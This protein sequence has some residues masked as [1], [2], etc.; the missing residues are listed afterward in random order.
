MISGE[1]VVLASVNGPIEVKLQNLVI[2][3]AYVEVNFRSK[4]G[5][6][7]VYDRLREQIIKETCEGAI[8]TA[9]Y[10]KTNISIQLQEMEDKSGVCYLCI[11]CVILLN[12]N[13]FYIFS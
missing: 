7:S 11:L 12:L 9:L 10:P 13:L 3:K 5:M 4:S 8:L 6:T 2:E 1:T